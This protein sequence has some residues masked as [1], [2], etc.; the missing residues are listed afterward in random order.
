MQRS[1][2]SVLLL[3][4]LRHKNEGAL[5]DL[6]FTIFQ[7]QNKQVANRVY[8]LYHLKRLCKKYPE[9]DTEVRAQISIIQEL[10]PMKPGLKVSVQNY[11]NT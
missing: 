3:L 11:L 4:P 6:Y 10:G 1:L 9:I 8:A 5:L 2:L 7:D